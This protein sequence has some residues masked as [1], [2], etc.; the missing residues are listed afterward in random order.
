EDI[1]L[2]GLYYNRFRYYDSN[3]GLYIAKDPIGLAGNNP[4]FYAYVWDSNGQVDVFGLDIPDIMIHY[5]N[6]EGMKAVLKEKKLRSNSK[7]KVYITDILMN[8]SEVER[9][10]FLGN[11]KYEGKGDYAIIFKLSE[12][13]KTNI[14]L[15]SDVLEYVHNGNLKIDEIIFTGKNPYGSFDFDY[16]TSLK[17]IQSQI[18][19]RKLYK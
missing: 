2:D 11:I 9:N 4:T 7:N 1:E 5:T 17:I 3:S 13:Q 15:S 6:R 8:P 16:N 19:N 12:V 10:I 14:A 18:D